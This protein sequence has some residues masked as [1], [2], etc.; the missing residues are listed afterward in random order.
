[1]LGLAGVVSVATSTA[2]KM[3]EYVYFTIA[4]GDTADPKD[5]AKEIAE[6]LKFSTWMVRQVRDEMDEGMLST[7][8][9][10]EGWEKPFTFS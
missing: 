2:L 5:I 4:F 1:M 10:I 3:A 9:C 6:Q 8:W 7:K